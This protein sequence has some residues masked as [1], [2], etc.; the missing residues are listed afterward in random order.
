MAS[1]VEGSASE[2]GHIGRE[3]FVKYFPRDGTFILFTPEFG[4]APNANFILS[5]GHAPR[6]E[7]DFTTCPP[8]SVLSR[9]LRALANLFSM[10]MEERRMNELRMNHPMKQ[11]VK[12]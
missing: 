1:W 5:L 12:R 8:V 10:T 2:D 11:R 9:L 3:D 4:R 7:T 6:H